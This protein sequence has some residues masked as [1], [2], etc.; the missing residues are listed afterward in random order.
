M[1][2]HSPTFPFG[3]FVC[4][5]GFWSGCCL[6]HCSS[7]RGAVILNHHHCLFFINAFSLPW[8]NAKSHQIRKTLANG[9]PLNRW[10]RSNGNSLG[11]SLEVFQPHSASPKAISPLALTF[12]VGCCFKATAQ[13]GGGMEIQQVKMPQSLL[14]ARFQCF[15]FKIFLNVLDF[16]PNT[17]A[18]QIWPRSYWFSTSVLCHLKAEIFIRKSKLQVNIS[19]SSV[20]TN[21]SRKSSPSPAI[22]CKWGDTQQRFW[23]DHMTRF[24]CREAPLA[25]KSVLTTQGE[26]LGGPGSCPGKRSQGYDPEK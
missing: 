14:L 3:F 22:S 10:E 25:A 23:R 8:E 4:L 9:E 26:T 6:P 18:K 24:A 21:D 16:K 13:L 1:E 17:S 7:S 20:S 11:G 5:V 15:S 2:Y 12:V 19:S